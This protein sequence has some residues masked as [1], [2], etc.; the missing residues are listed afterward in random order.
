MEQDRALFFSCVLPSILTPSILVLA[1][2]AHPRHRRKK[3]SSLDAPLEDMPNC[4]IGRDRSIP[5]VARTS[6]AKVGTTHWL[7]VRHSATAEETREVCCLRPREKGFA[8][9]DGWVWVGGWWS[10]GAEPT[11]VYRTS[12]HSL[13]ALLPCWACTLAMR[14]RKARAQSHRT[15]AL[16]G[17]STMDAAIPKARVSAYRHPGRALMGRWR[18]PM[19]VKRK[20]SLLSRHHW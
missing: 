16:G 11:R 1:R 12:G 20:T 7:H 5:I 9:V 4:I 18:E 6:R 13:L 17:R 2:P 8:L 10:A 15:Q 19:P 3:K 14:G